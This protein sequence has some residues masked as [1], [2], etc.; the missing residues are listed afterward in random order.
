MDIVQML[1]NGGAK[2]NET[3]ESG[4]TALWFAAQ[5]GQFEAAKVLIENGADLNIKASDGTTP[6]MIA[7]ANGYREL[8]EHLKKFGTRE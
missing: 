2:V 8:A 1:L 6:A 4:Q 5:Q 7:E 3:K